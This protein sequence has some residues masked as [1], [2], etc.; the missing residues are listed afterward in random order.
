MTISLSSETSSA[1]KNKAIKNFTKML[2]ADM[3]AKVE[4]A[5]KVQTE[6]FMKFLEAKPTSVPHIDSAK[7]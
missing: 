2:K 6:A 7:L 5:L 1:I 3:D 4:A